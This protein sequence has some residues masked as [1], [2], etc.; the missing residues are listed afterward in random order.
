MYIFI[1]F[2][3]F[4]PLCEGVLPPTVPNWPPTYNLSM[5]TISM[6]CNS[7]GW[8]SPERGATFGILSYDWSNYKEA[9]AKAEPMD[10]EERLLS[11]AQM[12]KQASKQLG[13]N[14]NVFVY[15][16]IVKALPWFSSIRNI[17]T[18]PA[19]SGFFLKFIPG[20]NNTHMDR[21]AAENQSKCS[22]LYHDQEQT[23]AVPTAVQPNPDG[24]CLETGCDCGRDL[25]CGEYLWDHRNG[26]QLRQWLL[27]EHILSPTALGNHLHVNTL[28]L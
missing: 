26:S 10:C 19:Y 20:H 18:D 11:Q 16:N 4:L 6:Q 8:S 3:L 2:L 7:S 14:T 13:S 9:W 5:S 15:R 17:L 22:D 28:W 24:S 25:P 27:Q 23:P 21:C 12:T 1:V